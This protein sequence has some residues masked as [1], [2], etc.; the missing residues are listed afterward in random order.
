MLIDNMFPHDS[1]GFLSS[2]NKV[3]Q[4]LF[5]IILL[6]YQDEMKYPFASNKDGANL[7]VDQELVHSFDLRNRRV[8]KVYLKRMTI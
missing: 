3:F 5:F 6:T 2:P 8:D 7:F 4:S 1:V